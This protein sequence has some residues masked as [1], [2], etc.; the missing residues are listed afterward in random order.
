[1]ATGSKHVTIV[2]KNQTVVPIIGKGIKVTWVVIANR[3]TPVEVMP[4]TLEKTDKMQ[5]VGWTKMYIEHRKEM[6]LQQLDLSGLEGWSGAKCTS[7]HAL[8]TKYHDIFSLEPGELGC[9]DLVKY[10]IRVVDD[11]P[12]KERF[13]RIPPPMGEQVRALMKEMLEAGAIHPSQSPWCNTIMLVRKKDGGLHFCI[14]FCKLNARTQKDSYPLPHIQEAIENLVG[15]RYF[16]CLD[17]NGGFWQIT[18]D[19]AWKQH[20]AFTVGNSGFFQVWMNALWV[21]QC[22]CNLPEV[23]AELPR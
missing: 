20:T 15:A 17:V 4:G 16:S 14:E 13:P 22:P 6:L 9:T 21:L 11:Q 3:V 12:F 18:M 5:G 19:E 23:N 1:M 7:T 2:I 8:L 10:E